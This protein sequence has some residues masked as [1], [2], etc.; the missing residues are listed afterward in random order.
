MHFDRA[1]INF[2]FGIQVV[3]KAILRDP[4]IDE[5]HATHLDNAMSFRDL[6]PRGFSI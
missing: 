3:V 4:A 1:L 2:A 6:K 5:L